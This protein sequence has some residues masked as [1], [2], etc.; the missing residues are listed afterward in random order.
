VKEIA[1][2]PVEEERS[3]QPKKHWGE[4]A[5][6]LRTYAGDLANAVRGGNITQTRIVMAE[7]QRRAREL[8]TE[9]AEVNP[10]L[11]PILIAGVLFCTLAAVIAVLFF[12]IGRDRE[13]I[14]PSVET[15]ANTR[16]S[17][18][19]ISSGPTIDITERNRA[20]LI[21]DLRVLAKDLFPGNIT[22]LTVE[23]AKTRASLH[24]LFETVGV[25]DRTVVP[26]N[27]AYVFLLGRIPAISAVVIARIPSYDTTLANMLRNEIDLARAFAGVL[28]PIDESSTL[29]FYSGRQFVDRTL[30]GV[31]A[32]TFDRDD[33]TARFVWGIVDHTFLILAPNVPAFSAAVR[34]LRA[35][36]VEI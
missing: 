36:T 19:S 32:R 18:P 25:S 2:E 6:P 16:P 12:G 24:H 33:G 23:S 27:A 14:D 13:V 15:T 26:Q 34:A 3:S 21:A 28:D 10:L 7:Q 1:Y 20:Q 17:P 31:D 5:L 29:P 9:A 22:T 30:D 8:P 11:R 35:K 4:K